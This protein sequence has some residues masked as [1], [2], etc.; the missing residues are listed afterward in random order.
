MFTNANLV[1]LAAIALGTRAAALP[2]Y[3][4][5][6]SAR[7]TMSRYVAAPVAAAWRVVL[8]W[9][10]RASSRRQ[11]RSLGPRLI[12]DFCLDPMEA[13]RETRKPFWR[14]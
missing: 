14:A 6:P 13:E 1:L 11:L 5:K 10:R 3:T 7:K 12:Q 8:E 9:Q 2:A 4:E